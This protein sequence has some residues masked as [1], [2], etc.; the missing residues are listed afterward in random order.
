VSSNR[1]F[2]IKDGAIKSRVQYDNS[3][4]KGRSIDDRYSPLGCAPALLNNA[5]EQALLHAPRE[6]LEKA[7][8]EAIRALHNVASEE[9]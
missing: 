9:E 8:T 4:L 6:K 3:N 2:T 5:L 7:L 1:V